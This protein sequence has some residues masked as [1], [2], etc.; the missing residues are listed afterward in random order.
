MGGSI[1]ATRRAPTYA[2]WRRT[3]PLLAALTLLPFA[4]TSA[5]HAY[6]A[7]DDPGRMT[8]QVTEAEVVDSRDDAPGSR[9][10]HRP[11]PDQHAEET[12]AEETEAERDLALASTWQLDPELLRAL[13]TD[14]PATTEAREQLAEIASQFHRVLTQY[15]DARAD[16]DLAQEVA[17]ESAA[18]LS[19]ARS[20]FRDAAALFRADRKLLVDVI[21]EAYTT[22]SVGDFGKLLSAETGQDLANG[23]VALQQMGQSQSSAVVAAEVSRD[24]LRAAADEVAAAERRSQESLDAANE[25]VERAT[26]A[27]AEVIED[28]RTARQLVEESA[29]AD[30]VAAERGYDVRVLGDIAFPLPRDASFVDQQNWGGKSKHWASVHTGD[31][32]STACGTPVLAATDGAVQI[33]TDQSWSGP[34]LVMVSTGPGKLSTWYAH[35]QT[36]VVEDGQEMEAGDL[37]GL[38]GALGNATGC[39][40]HFEVH[41]DGG[42]IYEDNI[43]PVSWLQEVEA[44]P[45]G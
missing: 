15:E 36:V 16:A 7:A 5:G 32:F 40:L 33:R 27:R 35:L 26:D 24:Q 29:L 13:P 28:L 6:S 39:H 14:S 10:G 8:E 11:T 45:K 41:T 3:T 31:D 22:D 38:V 25:A 18:A 20:A 42:G 17:R 43:D 44:Y 9:H 2:L 19:H 21:I 34:W 37:L 12:E 1:K 30:Q 4:G 23:L